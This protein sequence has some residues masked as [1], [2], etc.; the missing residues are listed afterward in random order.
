MVMSATGTLSDELELHGQA[1][2]GRAYVAGPMSNI[3]DFN[4]PAFR[5]AA[6]VLRER[7]WSVLSPVELDD[8]AGLD[9][10][11]YEGGQG[12]SASDYAGFLSRDIVKI[13]ETGVTAIVVLPGWEN[14][15]G[16]KTEVA[17][18]RAV[19]LDILAYP[20]LEPVPAAPAGQPSE[21]EARDPESKAKQSN[22]KDVVGSTKL[23]M[24]LWPT[25][26]TIQGA[27]ALLD[28]ALKYGR[29]NWREAG[30]RYSV[31]YDA[32]RRHL[33]A[34]FEGEDIDPDSGLTHEAH[35]LATLAI[36]VDA[37][38]AGKLIDDRA[39]NGSGY[40]QAVTDATADVARLQEKHAE[41]SPRHWTIADNS[42]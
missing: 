25:T 9:V 5:E 1:G 7:G 4:Q 40:R 23:P 17:F 28:G 11:A 24:H 16:A 42:K 30:V 38:A 18:G 37:R 3:D 14:S 26:A 34:A 27:L 19:G 39:Y 35:A 20:S 33:D 36:I 15:G 13:A 12:L 2:P 41:R 22:P 31:Y 29:G 10:T 8:E 32:A 6:G 21:A